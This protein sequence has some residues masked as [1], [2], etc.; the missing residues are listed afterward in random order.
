MPFI[1][2]RQKSCLSPILL[3]N[4]VYIEWSW[5]KTKKKGS[6]I[7]IMFR[8]LVNLSTC[9]LNEYFTAKQL[10]YF[11]WLSYC[12][13]TVNNDLV[14]QNNKYMNQNH[15]TPRGNVMPSTKNCNTENTTICTVQCLIKC[16][17]VMTLSVTIPCWYFCRILGWWRRVLSAVRL[18]Q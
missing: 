3:R 5:C 11:S 4:L 18:F 6:K 9:M 14:T 10:N 12:L 8:R 7:R 1:Q 16:C 15:I 17:R 13:W 2:D